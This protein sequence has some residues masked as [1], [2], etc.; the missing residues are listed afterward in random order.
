MITA[1]LLDPQKPRVQLELDYDAAVTLKLIF[2]RI[3]G[4]EFTTR[5][6]HTRDLNTALSEAYKDVRSFHDDVL[7]AKYEIDERGFK[8]AIYF[9]STK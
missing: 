5:R 1:K 6:K 7:S 4:P 8:D 9:R 2:D 3:G